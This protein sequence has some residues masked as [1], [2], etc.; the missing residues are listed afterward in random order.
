MKQFNWLKVNFTTLI[1]MWLVATAINFLLK[2]YLENYATT[3]LGQKKSCLHFNIHAL[4]RLASCISLVG[5]W[6][7]QKKPQFK[8]RYKRYKNYICIYIYIYIYI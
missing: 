7:N 2:I 8:K 5:G 6:Q 1:F 3:Q 4:S